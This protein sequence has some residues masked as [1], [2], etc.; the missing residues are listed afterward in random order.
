MIPKSLRLAVVVVGGVIAFESASGILHGADDPTVVSR[1]KTQDVQ[2]DGRA[3]EWAQLTAIPKGP[4]VAAFNDAD[5]LYLAVVSS[6]STVRRTLA[7]GLVVWL[8][9]SGS[10]NAD[11]GLQLPGSFIL[12]PGGSVD[13]GAPPASPETI[14]EVDWLGP[15]KR[16]QLLAITPEVGIALASGTEAGTLAYEIKLPLAPSSSHPSAVGAQPGRTI[17]L[18]LFT[19]DVPKATRRKDRGSDSGSYGRGYNPYDPYGTG[20]YGGMG[21]SGGPP[22]MMQ[23]DSSS[24]AKPPAMKLWLRLQ[25]AKQ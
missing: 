17:A 15:G 4:S 3:G 1:W 6:D 13:T 9:P 5:F 25:L 18:G 8:D 10:R 24:P 22:P 23:N 20:V 7:P 21:V 16:R 19:P 2:I 14:D 12:A 11:V